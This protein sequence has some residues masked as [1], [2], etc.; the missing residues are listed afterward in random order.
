[1]RCSRL[2]RP[3]LL[4]ALPLCLAACAAPPPPVV[5][6]PP[7]PPAPPPP[8]HVILDES[9]IGAIAEL[10]RMEDRRVVDSVRVAGL[11]VHP[12]PQVRGRA[13]LAA[14]RVGDRRMAPLLIRALGDSAVYVRASAALALG[15]LGD[16]SVAVV[17]ALA[18]VALLSPPDD[19]AAVEATAALGRL[20]TVPASTALLRLLEPRTELAADTLARDTLVAGATGAGADTSG[21]AG[22]GAMADST[23]PAAPPV[24]HAALLAIWRLPRTSAAVDAVAAHTAA[25]DVAARWRATYALMRMA[26]P[27]SMERLAAL[28]DDDDAL[29]RSLATRALRA[30]PIDSAGR[31]AATL[32]TLRGLLDDPHPHVRINALGALGTYRDST[33]AADV[34]GALGGEDRNVAI[35]AAQALGQLRGAAAAAALAATAA[36]TTAPIALRAAALASLVRADTARGT[37]LAADWVGSTDWLAR[38]YGARALAAAPWSAAGPRL[39]PLV[40]DDDPRVAAAAVAAIN[41]SADSTAS[42]RPLYIEALASGDAGVRAAAA[43]GLTA[44]AGP[45][46]LDV[47][48]Q[49]YE[50]AQRDPSND[51]ALAAVDGL[52]KLDSL[53][54][55]VRRSFF[56]RFGRANDPIVR[57]RVAQRLGTDGWGDPLPAEAGR[58]LNV[59]LDVVRD[60]VATE[61]A[62][63]ARPRARIRTAGGVITLELFG[64]DAPL[65]VRNFM[66]LA[67]GGYFRAARANGSPTHRW[68]RVVP[69][70]VLQDGDTRGDGSGGPGY[71]IRDEINRHRYLRGTLGMALSGPDT[72]GSQFFIT[73][74]P[75]PHL[76]GG[77]TVFGRV[78][79]GMDVVDRVIQDDPILAIEVIR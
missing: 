44:R 63:V 8:A 15:Q 26:A 24:V 4:R 23:P 65:T 45:A 51:A 13:A 37:A 74:S 67:A 46:D 16:T 14:G 58:P 57:R 73:H 31:R 6:E 77:Y 2:I 76:D 32:G 34:V 35:A 62:G 59:Y 22:T 50:R 9:A 11:L 28:V 75:Q 21:I 42:L 33:I 5:V 66:T 61:L 40:R 20:G 56:L 72:G 41:A 1:V 79:D 43:Q 27:T 7:P 52:A 47:L 48:L 38:I 19:T 49:A 39:R 36:D 12:E 25:A 64:A 71:A 68:H 53:G 17:R 78:V 70:F 30:V 10:L 3:E 54:L 29:V 69:N 18:D 60:L 55:P